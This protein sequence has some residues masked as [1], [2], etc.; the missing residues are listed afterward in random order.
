LALTEF[1]TLLARA[2]DLRQREAIEQAL[3][4]IKGWAW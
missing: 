4:T 3:I 1:E 2:T